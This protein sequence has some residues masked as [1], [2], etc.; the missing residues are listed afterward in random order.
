LHFIDIKSNGIK[1]TN[2]VK[3]DLKQRGAMLVALGL[4]F[5][6]FNDEDTKR[7]KYVINK[8]MQMQLTFPD[9]EETDDAD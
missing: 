6:R 1:E 8:I 2:K 4:G 9:M 3:D 5:P 7:I